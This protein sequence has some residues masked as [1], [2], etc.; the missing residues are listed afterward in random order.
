MRRRR[1]DSAEAALHDQTQ[2]LPKKE[3]LIVF[4]TMTAALFV[5]FVDQNG[6]GVLLPSIAR[7]LNAQSSISWAGTSALVAN[8]IFQILYGR[9]SDL[10]GRKNILLSALVLLSLSDLACGLS[11]N[12]TMLYVFRGIAGVAIGGIT[13]LT[14]MIVSDIVTLQDRGKYQ[15]IL[16][17]AVGMGNAVGPLIASGFATHTTWRGLFYFLAPVCMLTVVPSWR[18][19]PTNMPKLNLRETLAKIDMLGLVT[20]TAA[21]IL[22]LIPISQ[23]GHDGYAWS[24]PEIIAMLCVGGACFV[25]FLLIE[26]RWA[27]LPMMP[28]GMFRKPSVAAMLAQSMLLGMCYYSYIYFIPLYLQNVKGLSPLLSAVMLLPL[29][30]TQSITS[31]LA[32]LFVSLK[33]KYGIVLWFGFGIWTVGSGLLTM[34]D[35]N[36]NLGLFAFFLILVGMG[37]GCTFQPTLVALQAQ[38]PA[39]QRA[40]VT[41]NRNFLRSSGG[42]IGLAVSSA[43]LAN[44]LTTILPPSLSNIANSS[45]AAPSLSDFSG[46][47][48]QLIVRAYAQASRNVFIWCTPLSG[49]SFMLCAFVRD[50]GLQRKE[51]VD[52]SQGDRDGTVEEITKYSATQRERSVD[53]RQGDP[54]KRRKR[55]PSNETNLSIDGDP[56]AMEKGPADRDEPV[57]DHASSLSEDHSEKSTAR[58]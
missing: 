3:L 49:L 29:V 14:M 45:F 52:H 22:L 51:E 24:S 31:T 12:S 9:L 42:A 39:V 28:L 20:G 10:F 15:G 23:G 56:S 25:A 26:W 7:D 38:T 17:A 35:G 19:L 46:A 33:N 37:T 58:R 32:G 13:S 30:V 16:G 11:V 5:C 34:A 57:D 2:L 48:Q 27:T 50:K 54:E 53:N 18:Y 43:V 8:T 47:E 44:T 36:T 21:V 40:V 55:R 4:S 1:D 41:S 6:I